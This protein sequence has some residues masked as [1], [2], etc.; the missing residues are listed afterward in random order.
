MV[1]GKSTPAVPLQL[2]RKVCSS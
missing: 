2:Q 1:E